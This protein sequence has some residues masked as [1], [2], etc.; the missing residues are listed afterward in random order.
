MLTR[1]SGM[2]VL[3]TETLVVA[4]DPDEVFRNGFAQVDAASFSG[5]LREEGCE[6]LLITKVLVHGKEYVEIPSHQD[7]QLTVFHSGPAHFAN[8][9]DS[10]PRKLAAEGRGSHSSRRMRM[11]HQ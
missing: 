4:F 11:A 3:V 8:G 2:W 5:M 6:V 10:V 7:E 9:A 1:R